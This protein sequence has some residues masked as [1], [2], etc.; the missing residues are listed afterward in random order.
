MTQSLASVAVLVEIF[1]QTQN[2]LLA[3]SY[4]SCAM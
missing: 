3:S 2:S 4:M 1:Q